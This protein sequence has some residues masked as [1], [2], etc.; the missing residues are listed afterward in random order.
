V[1]IRKN[2]AEFVS[3]CGN[4]NKLSGSMTTENLFI[5]KAINAQENLGRKQ[6]TV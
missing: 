4:R 3:S 6:L 1:N 5:R 2:R